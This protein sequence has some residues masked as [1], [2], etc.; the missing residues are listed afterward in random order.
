MAL[1]KAFG[2]EGFLDRLGRAIFETRPRQ[3]QGRKGDA[4][5]REYKVVSI[6]VVAETGSRR[7]DDRLELIC[8]QNAGEGRRLVAVTTKLESGHTSRWFLFFESGAD[9]ASN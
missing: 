2:S 4:E 8:N 9:A 7:V 3:L 5:M 6:P 1:E